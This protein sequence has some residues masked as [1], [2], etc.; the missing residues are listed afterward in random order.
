MNIQRAVLALLLMAGLLAAAA[1]TTP[2]ADSG[3]APWPDTAEKI[4]KGQI[5]VGKTYGM[6][7]DQR[8]HRIHESTLGLDCATCHAER[9]PPS[10]RPFTLPPA[11]DASSASPGPVDRRSCQGCHIA[12]PARDIYGSRAP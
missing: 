4:R 8:F 3:V 5:D 9:I 2:A 10:A 1:A 12:G 7:P 11:V 6:K